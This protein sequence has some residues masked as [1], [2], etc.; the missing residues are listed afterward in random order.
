MGPRRIPT[1]TV[2]TEFG[3]P[4]LFHVGGTVFLNI[5]LATG[6]HAVDSH[7]RTDEFWST[8]NDH[9]ITAVC[10]LAAMVPSC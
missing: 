3:Q 6:D 4:L 5:T 10:L 9:S 8:V 1:S 2:T 7:F